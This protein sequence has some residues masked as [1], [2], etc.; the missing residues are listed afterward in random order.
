MGHFSLE[1]QGLVHACLAMETTQTLRR[2]SSTESKVTLPHH[3]LIVI[4][5][6]KIDSRHQKFDTFNVLEIKKGL[7]LTD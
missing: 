4:Q 6:I 5:K 3:Q 2:T 7:S 1:A